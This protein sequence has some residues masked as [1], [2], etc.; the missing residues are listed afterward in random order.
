M[1]KNQWANAIGTSNFDNQATQ[2]LNQ[3][4]ANSAQA[5]GDIMLRDLANA[6]NES[7]AR[8]AQNS[9][10]QDLVKKIVLMKVMSDPSLLSNPKI[11]SFLS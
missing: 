6:T 8:D 10:N 1:P 4:R 11:Q 5:V 9:S 2:K 3:T 7:S